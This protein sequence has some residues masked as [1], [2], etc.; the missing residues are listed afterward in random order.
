MNSSSTLLTN[1]SFSCF[2]SQFKELSTNRG[3]LIQLRLKKNSEAK[4]FV[5]CNQVSDSVLYSSPPQRF[6]LPRPNLSV[7]R[8]G[9]TYEVVVEKLK[10]LVLE[11]ESLTE[12]IDRVKRLL[13][14][15]ATLPRFDESAM[16][17]ANRVTGCT[18]QV[19]LE[20]RLDECGRVRFC[21]DSDSEITKGFISC[22]I[23]ILDGAEPEEVLMV[24]AE[25]LGAMNVGLHGKAQSRV[26]TWRNVL[27]SMQK[28]TMVLVAKK[29]I[30]SRTSVSCCYR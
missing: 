14:Y 2:A 17:E 4:F 22:L 18:T 20:G 19:W 7:S 5:K 1:I 23:W 16:V 6:N 9:M 21:A 13:H 3:N 25:D 30:E 10:R 15:A 27:I 24:K 8:A 11:F 29:E 12:P 26:N 28:R